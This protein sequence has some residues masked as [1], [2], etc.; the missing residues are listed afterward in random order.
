M[1]TP[2]AEG[3]YKPQFFSLD[4]EMQPLPTCLTGTK[5][6]LEKGNGYR[7][8]AALFPGKGTGLL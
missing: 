5:K 6:R 8:S 1:L 7:G 3:N 2:G 4:P